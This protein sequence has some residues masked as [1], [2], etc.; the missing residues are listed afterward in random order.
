MKANLF[1]VLLLSTLSLAAARGAWPSS[2]VLHPRGSLSTSQ[3]IGFLGPNLASTVRTPH[4]HAVQRQRRRG[5]AEAFDSPPVERYTSGVSKTS[6]IIFLHA[7]SCLV[8]TCSLGGLQDWIANL[9]SLPTSKILRRITS[10]LVV[11]TGM[12]WV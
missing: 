5:R 7:M 6:S 3:T 1:N 10:H 11:N 4:K 8:L 9:A 12:A 2:K